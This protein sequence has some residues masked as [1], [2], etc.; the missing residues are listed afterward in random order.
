M[1]VPL[2]LLELLLRETSAS[3][4]PPVKTQVAILLMYDPSF[5]SNPSHLPGSDYTHSVLVASF[6]AGSVNA[7]TEC[8]TLTIRDDTVVEGDEVFTVTIIESDEGVMLG[9]N[10]RNIT[11]IDNDSKHQI[12]SYTLP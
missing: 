2:S 8:I 4:L 6:P 3:C 7:D 9:N 5:E 11:I 10:Q 12:D 1:C